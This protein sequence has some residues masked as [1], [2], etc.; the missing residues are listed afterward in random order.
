MVNTA[1]QSD[2]AG[3]GRFWLGALAD[4][5]AKDPA[6]AAE[7]Y[8]AAAVHTPGDH[9]L[10]SYVARHQGFHLLRSDHAEAV[11]L[12]RRSYVLRSALG[13]RPQ[14]AAAAAALADVLPA[15][16]EGRDLREAAL[17][18]ARDLELSWLLA[19]LRRS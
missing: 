16:R 8:A 10:E 2:L 13:A 14:T 7:H 9:L 18:T 15:G 1:R 4:N 17:L 3:W 6:S 11:T 5:V 12:L 19:H